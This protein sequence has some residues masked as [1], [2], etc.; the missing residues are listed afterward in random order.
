[1]S[2]LSLATLA[3]RLLFMTGAANW[4]Y[5]GV[6]YVTALSTQENSEV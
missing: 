1:M 5:S 4:T 6:S 2:V 3:D